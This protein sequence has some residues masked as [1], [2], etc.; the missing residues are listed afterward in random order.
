MAKNPAAYFSKIAAPGF[1]LLFVLIFSNQAA[2]FTFRK[3]DRPR[4]SA[5]TIAETDE[6]RIIFKY[7]RKESESR[8]ESK[9]PWVELSYKIA[10]LSETPGQRF[11]SAGGGKVCFLDKDGFMVAADTFSIKDLE[12][13]DHYGFIGLQENFARQIVSADLVPIRSEEKY[14]LKEKEKKKDKKDKRPSS[15]ASKKEEE[16]PGEVIESPEPSAAGSSEPAV[17]DVE[18]LASEIISPSPAPSVPAVEQPLFPAADAV[19]APSPV[20]SLPAAAEGSPVSES[21]AGT[22]LIAEPSLSPA[23]AAGASPAPSPSPSESPL[24]HGGVGNDEVRRLLNAQ[25]KTPATE[26]PPSESSIDMP[27]V[28]GD[29]QASGNGTQEEKKSGVIIKQTFV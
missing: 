26:I 25:S 19:P 7:E 17:K 27:E 9:S 12:T 20:L 4:Q 2:A 13:G 22:V 24:D 21:E 10:D 1:V 16:S 11:A 29:G 18:A 5:A 23:R 28:T 6:Y 3:S 8:R 15:G 14:K